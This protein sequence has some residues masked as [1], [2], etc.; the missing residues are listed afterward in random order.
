MIQVPACAI[1]VEKLSSKGIRLYFMEWTLS[2]PKQSKQGLASCIPLLLAWMRSPE[3]TMAF[4]LVQPQRSERVCDPHP[5]RQML[6]T[7]LGLVHMTAVHMILS[8]SLSAGV[9]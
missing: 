9:M 5:Q 8:A 1:G 2:A 4:A 3:S 7:L 6:H